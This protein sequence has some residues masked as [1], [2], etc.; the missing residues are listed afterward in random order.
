MTKTAEAP[1]ARQSTPNI[2]PSAGSP[3]ANEE[4]V[5]CTKACFSRLFIVIS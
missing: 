4:D 2:A 3:T 5:E 1:G